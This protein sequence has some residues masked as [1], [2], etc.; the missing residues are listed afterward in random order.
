VTKTTEY[1]SR[2]LHQEP[3][4]EGVAHVL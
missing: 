3:L 1:S 4:S 2:N